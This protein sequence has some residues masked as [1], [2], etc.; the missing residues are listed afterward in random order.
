MQSRIAASLGDGFA[1]TPNKVWGTTKYKNDTEPT[2]F[3]GIYGLPDFYA[4]WRHKGPKYILWAGSDITH[5]RHGYWLDETGTIKLDP[6]PMAKWI[7]DNCKSYVENEMEYTEL[8]QLG[9]KAEIVPS[10]LGDVK[11]F[12]MSFKPGP[13]RFY[14]SVSG[15][16][17]DLYGW[18]DI[19]PLSDDYPEA[20]FHLYGNTKPWYTDKPNIIVHGRVSQSEMDNEIKGMTGAL[21]L[22]RHDGFSEILAKSLLWGQWPVSPYIYY[23]H[24]ASSIEEMKYQEG[25]NVQGREH[26]LRV[27]NNY[28]FNVKKH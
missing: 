15:D 16:D 21:R 13:L 24:V 5:L 20:E 27:M 22:T 8:S 14:T 4:L 25:P 9:I 2:V 1:G 18:D 17:F 10:F 19:E 6:K 28:P 26:Y 12:P 23:P 11:K 7:N 3:F